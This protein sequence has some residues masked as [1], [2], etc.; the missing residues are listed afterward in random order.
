MHTLDLSR[1]I[2]N[3]II[4]LVN[5]CKQKIRSLRSLNM[6]LLIQAWH[7]LF[8]NYCQ[9]NSMGLKNIFIY[10]SQLFIEHG[11]QYVVQ[12]VDELD[13]LFMSFKT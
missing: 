6:F 10:I 5:I 13:I 3:S 12:E 9:L 7:F 2:Y 11:K 4:E 1:I 8:Q